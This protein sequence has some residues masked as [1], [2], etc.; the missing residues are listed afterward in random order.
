MTASP[1][2]NSRQSPMACKLSAASPSRPSNRLRTSGGGCRSGAALRKAT[3]APSQRSW[4]LSAGGI[5]ECCSALG[6][7]DGVAGRSNSD[8]VMLTERS[9]TVV[10]EGDADSLM[11]RP[12]APPLRSASAAASSA[13][14][15]MH[16]P[17]PHA[18]DISVK[19]LFGILAPHLKDMLDCSS[20][21]SNST[22]SSSLSPSELY[23]R[24][25]SSPV[26][27]S[28]ASQPFLLP[29]PS[30]LSKYPIRTF[31]SPPSTPSLL[32]APTVPA[33]QP[34]FPASPNSQH[35]P[36]SP[37]YVTRTTS[38]SSAG[39]PR[40]PNDTSSTP[41]PI[42]DPFT[43]IVQDHA[44]SSRALATST[45]L[46]LPVCTS[47][48]PSHPLLFALLLVHRIVSKSIDS[49]TGRLV[50]PEGLRSPTRLL[51]AGLVLAESQLSDSQTST[52]VWGRLF[53]AV[54]EPGKVGVEG[55]SVAA[56][57]KR[58]G[59][60]CLGFAAHVRVEEYSAWLAGLKR[61]LRS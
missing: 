6:E 9:S 41:L 46:H 3:V 20:M 57:V 27:D 8:V 44:R 54:Q 50:L 39:Y 1:S 37:P 30:S 31:A 12:L 53:G 15:S 17:I 21:L 56:C 26:S 7:R 55:R 29:R 43:L 61:V 28:D 58:E 19:I 32:A 18:V 59:L 38:T 49:A 36:L 4:S 45:A 13:Y 2:S 23:N 52:V 33:P 51:L 5:G 11:D 47:S 10:V 16:L 14:P 35:E 22:C 24:L 60:A 48:G 25:P 42:P 34:T 40:S